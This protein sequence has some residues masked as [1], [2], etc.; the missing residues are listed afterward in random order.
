MAPSFFKQFYKKNQVYQFYKILARLLEST[1]TLKGAA[2][3][4]EEPELQL[5]ELIKLFFLVKLFVK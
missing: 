5:V 3:H 2:G 1:D 4:A